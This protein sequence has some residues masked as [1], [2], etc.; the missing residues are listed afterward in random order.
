MAAKPSRTPAS[1]RANVGPHS[2]ASHPRELH[3][4][5]C[6][7]VQSRLNRAVHCAGNGRFHHPIHWRGLQLSKSSN[8]PQAAAAMLPLGTA[9]NCRSI[10]RCKASHSSNRIGVN[11]GFI[12]M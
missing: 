7:T 12:S 10:S 11:I 1:P 5:D 8:S 3:A 4:V 2:E 9:P 6:G